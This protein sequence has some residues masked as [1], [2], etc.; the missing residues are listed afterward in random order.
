M[1]LA[2]FI[3]DNLEPI[4]QGWEDFA[5]TIEPAATAMDSLGLRDHAD[6]MLRAIAVDLRTRQT[7]SQ[8]RTKSRGNGP[9]SR[10]ETPAE[11][12]AVVRHMS[13]FTIDQMVSEYRA[14]RASV[15]SLWLAKIKSGT[16]FEVQ[17]MT[18]FNEAIDQALAESVAS[19]S[20]AVTASQNIFLGILGH[21]LRSPLSAILLSSE[22]LVHGPKADERTLR[23]GWRIHASVNRATRIVEDLLDFT[24]SQL[25]T[26]IPVRLGEV[27]ITAVCHGIVEETRAAFP[28]RD[29]QLQA[30]GDVHGFIDASRIEQVLSNLMGNA[31]E[32]GRVDS[33]IR[34]TLAV[35]NGEALIQVHNEGTP[36]SAELL[37][38]V[39]NFMSRHSQHGAEDIGAGSG[40]GLGLYIVGEIVAAHAGHI[41]VQSSAENGTTFS[42]R[43]PL[44]APPAG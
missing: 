33:P 9:E 7:A 30:P 27:D 20:R 32:H 28:S 18:R 3:L 2:D 23:M 13:G 35:I 43:L 40:L 11:T 44:Q 29:I 14:L 12:H 15:L 34:M 37:P 10:H 8:Q 1:R 26:G 42:V 24:R 17:D 38:F 36:I 6:Q 5:R 25:G 16:D 41:E 22:M 39:F 19:Y 4:L 21:D 31:M